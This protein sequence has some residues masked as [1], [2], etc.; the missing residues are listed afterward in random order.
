ML[1]QAG[2][3]FEK[4]DKFSCAA[5]TALCQRHAIF[6]PNSPLSDEQ[7]YQALVKNVAAEADTGGGADDGAVSPSGGVGGGVGG[8]TRD[9]V[10][11]VDTGNDVFDQLTLQMAALKQTIV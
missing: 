8:A 3:E 1:Y 6:P 4:G 11:P 9:L 7:K 10:S 2:C 5:F